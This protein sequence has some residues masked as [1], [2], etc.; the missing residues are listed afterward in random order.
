MA[1]RSL[2]VLVVDDETSIADSLATIL[3]NHGF[4]VACA[5][6]GYSAIRIAETL[7]PDVIVSDVLMP[8]INGIDA[9]LTIWR[10]LPASKFVFVSRNCGFQET[11][12]SARVQGLRFIYLQKP[13]PPKFLIGYLEDCR[14]QL[15]PAEHALSL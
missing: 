12:R 5:Y 9:A 14:R 8:G 4:E 13:A 2:R 1:A 6:S 15:Q 3:R 11:L 7:E 10:Q